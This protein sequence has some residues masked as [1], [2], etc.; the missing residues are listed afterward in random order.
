[1]DVLIIKIGGNDIDDENFLLELS[2]TLRSVN[3]PVILVHGG[4]KEI[5]RLQA[6]LGISPSYVEGVRITDAESMVLVEMVLCGL[7]NKRVVGHLVR[8]GVDAIGLSGIDRGLIRAVKMPH[9][10][11]DMGHTGIVTAVNPAVLR[12]VLEIGLTPVVAPVCLG[13]SVH[14]NVNADHVAG[15]IAAALNANRL[16][17]LTNVPGV[18]KDDEL[19][20]EMSPMQAEALIASGTINGG[21]IPK[22]RTAL[23]ALQSGVSQVAITNLAGLASNQA[24][25]FR[26]DRA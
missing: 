26:L 2:S 15:A 7:V 19:V 16:I 8:A 12:D 23:A 9:P 22:V 4:G 24:T 5:S 13:D 6:Q 17:F 3:E 21:M 18:L 10:E 25:V 1:M 20:A 11:I 14:F